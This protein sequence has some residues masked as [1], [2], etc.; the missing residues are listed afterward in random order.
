MSYLQDHSP[1]L[2]L[3][4]GMLTAFWVGRRF[5]KPIH[6]HHMRANEDPGRA[7]GLYDYYRETLRALSDLSRNFDFLFLMGVMAF[8]LCATLLISLAVFCYHFAPAPVLSEI[9]QQ[10][11]AKAMVIEAINSLDTNKDEE[12]MSPVM[13][14][15]FEAFGEQD[16]EPPH[17]EAVP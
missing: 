13:I 1:T 14:A 6:H 12:V 11:K 8:I 4:L 10:A 7:I 2:M 3:V 15:A 16:E 9:E 5:S 17:G